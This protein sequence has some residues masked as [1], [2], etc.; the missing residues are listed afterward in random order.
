MGDIYVYAMLIIYEYWVIYRWK[1][2]A[3]DSQ[4]NVPDF[5]YDY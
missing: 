1:S 4:L 5:A 3:F 2:T